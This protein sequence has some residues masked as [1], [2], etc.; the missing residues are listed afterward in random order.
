MASKQKRLLSDFYDHIKNTLANGPD[1]QPD[2]EVWKAVS[3][4]IGS[5]KRIFPFPLWYVIPLAILLLAAGILGFFL[6]KGQHAAIS[7]A[8]APIDTLINQQELDPPRIQTVHDTLVLHDTMMQYVY[9]PSQENMQIVRDTVI[10][11]AF[12]D[13]NI[14]TGF[15]L[16]VFS[17][18]QPA[19]IDSILLFI[20]DEL[21]LQTRE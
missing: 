3:T 19:E 4:G 21:Y 18:N 14:P 15:D 2:D 11:P 16:P 5:K 10:L 17:L 8:I 13:S 12:A 1:H 20:N 7:P 9:L 6:G